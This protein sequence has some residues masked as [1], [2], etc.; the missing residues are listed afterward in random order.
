VQQKW[1]PEVRQIIKAEALLKSFVKSIYQNKILRFIRR[2]HSALYRIA[3]LPRWVVILMRAMV[4]EIFPSVTTRA[5]IG[6]VRNVK[7]TKE[8]NGSRKGK[9]NYCPAVIIMWF[10]LC[11]KNSMV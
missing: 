10:L 8:K 6:I 1:K 7:A 11:P 9:R 5:G 3:G 2:K 4:A